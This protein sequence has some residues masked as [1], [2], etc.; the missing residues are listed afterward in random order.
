MLTNQQIFQF[1]QELQSGNINKEKIQGTYEKVKVIDEELNVYYE[2]VMKIKDREIK[3]E[4]ME[5][6]QK[7]K[8]RTRTMV[9]ILRNS[10]GS[11]KIDNEQIA[12]LNDLAY[13]AV[14]HQGLQKKL[15][16]RALKNEGFYKKMNEEIKKKSKEIDEKALREKYKDII[17]FTGSCPLSCNDAVESLIYGDCL[18]LGL[19]I[20]RSEAAIA[21]PSKLVIKDIIP[22]F[23]GA[24]S[25]IDSASFK[26]DRN[27][28]AHGGFDSRNAGS[29][30]EGLGR[31]NISGV[32]PLYLF[33][34][35]WEIAR[36]K[37]P[38]VFG[39]MCTLDVMGF[40]S[41]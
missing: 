3:K 17:E 12:K 14:R 2:K 28:M 22:T 31:E 25:F 13:K 16:E 27:S 38:P 29:L 35:H 39:F 26:I 30:A 24:D 8:E 19:D 6:L 37:C 36:K 18:C 9:E 4:L 40:A 1:V 21:D 11:T 20:G 23:M 15:D 5:S 34:E 32:L 7:C 41:S 10:Q 33:K